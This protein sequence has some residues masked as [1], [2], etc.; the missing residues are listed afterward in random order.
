[1]EN[2]AYSDD[3]P[4]VDPV[5]RCTEC[6]ILVH[7]KTIKKIGMCQKCGNKR[8]RKV[9]TLS[10]EEMADLKEK[11]IDPVFLALFGEVEDV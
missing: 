1:M 3:G 10:G 2:P 7:R 5:V 6:H 8:V 9:S 4:F 11:N